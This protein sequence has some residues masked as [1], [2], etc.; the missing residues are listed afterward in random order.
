MTIRE[1]FQKIE[2]AGFEDTE[3]MEVEMNS[4]KFYASPDVDGDPLSYRE[5]ALD[6]DTGEYSITLYHKE[7]EEDD[8]EE[9]ET[10]YYDEDG[11]VKE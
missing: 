8:Y 4:D 11:N 10:T 7:T 9:V 2:K 5:F 3:L 6:L 1:M